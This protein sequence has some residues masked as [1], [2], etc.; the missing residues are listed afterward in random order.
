MTLVAAA[1]KIAS[2]LRDGK[3]LTDPQVNLNVEEYAG[4]DITVL[5]EVHSPGRIELLAPRHLD[6]VIAMAGGETEYAGK[7]IEIRHEEGVTPRTEVIPTREAS[8]IR[9]SVIPLYFLGKLSR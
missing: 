8:I 7:T 4:R 1:T 9:F 6:D 5:G 3:I 2:S